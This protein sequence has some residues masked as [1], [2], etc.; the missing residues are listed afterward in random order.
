MFLRLHG[1]LLDGNRG[2]ESGRRTRSR[3]RCPPDRVYAHPPGRIPGSG[4]ESQGL[5]LRRPGKKWPLTMRGA[6]PIETCVCQYEQSADG[7]PIVDTRPE[8]SNAWIAGGGSGHGYN[9]APRSGRCSP[10]RRSASGRRNPS[11]GWPGSAPEGRSWQAGEGAPARRP[12]PLRFSEPLDQ[13]SI[14]TPTRKT[15]GSRMATISL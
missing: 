7:H 5:L 13:N 12:A 2:G 9:L 6:P 8:A 11:S 3:D 15:R 4:Y 10:G 1:S 14:R